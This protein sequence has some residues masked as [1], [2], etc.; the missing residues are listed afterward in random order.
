MVG[1]T[2]LAFYWFLVRDYI[3]H[4]VL[5]FTSGLYCTIISK[6]RRV[7]EYGRHNSIWHWGLFTVIMYMRW[8]SLLAMKSNYFSDQNAHLYAGSHFSLFSQ[9]CVWH[10]K[11][12]RP[13]DLEKTFAYGARYANGARASLYSLQTRRK[14]I[15][16]HYQKHKT[17]LWQLLQRATRAFIIEITRHAK[18]LSPDGSTIVICNSLNVEPEF[19]YIVC[20]CPGFVMSFNR[21]PSSSR[22][23][24][25][26]GFFSFL[27]PLCSIRGNSGFSFRFALATP[28][29]GQQTELAIPLLLSV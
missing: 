1:P 19:H 16:S 21:Q 7:F 6:R 12:A 14:S 20:I 22:P 17:T 3:I 28:S 4:R 27:I 25:I 15:K 10:F 5:R 11:R 29:I 23:R 13:S 9:V 2:I 26:Y 24:Y 18:D 8:K